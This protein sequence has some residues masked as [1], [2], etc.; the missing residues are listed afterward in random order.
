M[1]GV[2]FLLLSLFWCEFVVCVCFFFWES[3]SY[4]QTHCM[5]FFQQHTFMVMKSLADLIFS[6]RYIFAGFQ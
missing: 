1:N 2:L 4:S 3:Q 6:T 5:S